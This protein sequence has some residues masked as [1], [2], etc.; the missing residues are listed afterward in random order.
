MA[1]TLNNIDNNDNEETKTYFLKDILI[2]NPDR[3][4]LRNLYE[5]HFN[6]LLRKEWT[7][8]EI[9]SY[10][11]RYSTSITKR[12][13]LNVI[14]LKEIEILLDKESKSSNRVIKLLREWYDKTKNS[15][16]SII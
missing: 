1:S 2:Y 6:K 7:I 10:D 14:T 11:P 15:P 9:P 8:I 13:K 5:K 16:Q 4:C 12:Q 3:S